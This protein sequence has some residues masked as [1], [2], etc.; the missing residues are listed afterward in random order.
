MSEDTPLA[1]AL[2][3]I[4]DDGFEL[5]AGKESAEV[6]YE[7]SIGKGWSVGA[8]ARSTYKGAWDA[9]VRVIWRPKPKL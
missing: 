5:D 2:S 8:W 9:A 3:K 1:D 7:Q 4:R 6:S